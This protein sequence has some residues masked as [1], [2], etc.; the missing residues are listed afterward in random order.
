[1]KT[2]SY[3]PSPIEVE[4]AYALEQLQSQIGELL[5]QNEVVKVENKITQDNPV[6]TFHLKDKDNDPHQVVV[7]IIQKPDDF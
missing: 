5:T 7:K 1:M 6:I 4:F 2:Q 3:N